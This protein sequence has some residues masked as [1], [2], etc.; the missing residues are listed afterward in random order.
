M[1]PSK[2]YEVPA[3]PSHLRRMATELGRPGNVQASVSAVP[4]SNPRKALNG[5]AGHAMSLVSWFF[6][7]ASHSFQGTAR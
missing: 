5:A 6:K 7:L 1:T 2:R 4:A 3:Y